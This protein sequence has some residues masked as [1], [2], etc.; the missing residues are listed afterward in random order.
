MA[1]LSL[2]SV[3]L[4]RTLSRGSLVFL[5]PAWD[6]GARPA[7]VGHLPSPRPAGLSRPQQVRPW[8][9]GLR[10]ATLLRQRALLVSPSAGDFLRRSLWRRGPTLGGKSHNNVGTPRTRSPGVFDLALSTLSLQRLVRD[11]SGFPT[12]CWC[13]GQSRLRLRLGSSSSCVC[14]SVSL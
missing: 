1:D 2:V 11:G 7:G 4:G 12:R 10:R 9:T 13:P 5:S 3:R 14:L 8:L 6:R